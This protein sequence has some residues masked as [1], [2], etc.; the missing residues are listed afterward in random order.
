MRWSA[1][2]RG[3][4]LPRHV[5]RLQEA[6]LKPHQIR[7]WLT[8]GRRIWRQSQ[9][10]YPALH[11]CNWASKARENVIWWH[12]SSLERLAPD[13]PL[14]P[15][16][17]QR[18]F[19]YI[20]HGTQ[21]LIA[22][23]DVAT[24]QVIC[25]TCGDTRTEVDFAAH[26]RVLIESEPDAKKWDLITDCLNTHQSESLVRLVAEIEGLEFDLGIKGES[27][28]LKS[29]K[30]RAAF[31]RLEPSCCLHYTPNI[32]LGSIKLK[33]GL[34]F[35][36]VSY[37]LLVSSAKTTSKPESLISSITLTEQWLNL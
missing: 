18:E 32:L 22:N 26:V 25:P 15:G 3:E 34:A 7:Y 6:Q 33:F 37:S 29:M 20:R 4:Y 31:K 10:H 12:P 8:P 36:Y 35:W 1:V 19:E 2:H 30:T 13:L 16:K 14:R 27:G 23:F 17:V 28:I 21:S 9:W 5:G 11:E 24:G